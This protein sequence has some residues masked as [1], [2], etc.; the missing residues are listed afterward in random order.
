M[1][2]PSEVVQEEENSDEPCS[3]FR[4]KKGATKRKDRREPLLDTIKIYVDLSLAKKPQQPS[5]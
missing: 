3:A 2:C 1:S 5:K 4:C